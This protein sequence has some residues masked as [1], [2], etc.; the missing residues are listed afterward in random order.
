MLCKGNLAKTIFIFVL[1]FVLLLPTFFCHLDVSGITRIMINDIASS[2]MLIYEGIGKLLTY[3]VL[4]PLSYNK[5]PN[6][7]MNIWSDEND[8][9]RLKG[10]TYRLVCSCCCCYGRMNVW[11]RLLLT[12]SGILNAAK[13]IV[14]S[15]N[16]PFSSSL[17]LMKSHSKIMNK[18]LIENALC[19]NVDAE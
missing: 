14:L 12:I 6:F 9:F 11:I 7:D 19:T 3:S 18:I 1:Q 13:A 2:I 8:N 10:I 16:I 5:Y 15:S 17:P 4:V